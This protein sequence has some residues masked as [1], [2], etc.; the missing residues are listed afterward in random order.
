INPLPL[1]PNFTASIKVYDGTTAAT[2]ATRTLA[3]T[4]IGTDAVSLTG[5]TAT[6]ASANVGT[7]TVTGSGFTLTGA[8][9]ANYYLSPTTATTT[10]SITPAPLTMTANNASRPYGQPNPTF[11]ATYSAFVNGETAGVL[12]GTL[13]ITTTA[14][15]TSPVVNGALVFTLA[16]VP[17]LEPVNPAPGN[18]PHGQMAPGTTTVSAVL[19]LFSGV[20]SN[21]IVANPTTPLTIT[22]EDAR[23][24]YSGLTYYG[25]PAGTA[26]VT[27]PLSANVFDIS[28]AIF[29][30]GGSNPDGAY[31][32]YPGDIRNATVTFVNRDANNAVL[33]KAPAVALLDPSV[34]TAG[35]ATCKA[36]VTIPSSGALEMT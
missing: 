16:N 26:S 6:F 17:L 10:A 12:S 4:I 32:P 13:T 18:P 30:P 28:N 21:F 14:I 5:G 7:W 31:D 27:V 9:T 8:A 25:V 36:N 1:A 24:Y 35:S 34:T 22:P 19:A 33:C 15:Q 29:A 20:N 2:I 23:A 11:T 3:G